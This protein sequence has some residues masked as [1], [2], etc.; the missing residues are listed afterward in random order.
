M[1]KAPIIVKI[2]QDKSVNK[3]ADKTSTSLFL[4]LKVK[5]IFN[6][7]NKHTIDI[8]KNNPIGAI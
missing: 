4:F 5:E 6:P 7:V 1:E 8:T 3:K 2:N